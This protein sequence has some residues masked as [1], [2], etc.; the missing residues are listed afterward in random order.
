MNR[1]VVIVGC[2]MLAFIIGGVVLSEGTVY[3]IL[4]IL[5]NLLVGGACGYIW[6]KDIYEEE[7][8]TLLNTISRLKKELDECKENCNPQTEEEFSLAGSVPP[9]VETAKKTKAK[10]TVK[11]K[12]KN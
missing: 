3:G 7:K 10:T 1:K 8:N 12:K 4:A 9:P 6:K 2:A 11:S 5:L